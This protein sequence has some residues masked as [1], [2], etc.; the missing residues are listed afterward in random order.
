MKKIT[1][2]L[3]LMA[4][5]YFSYSQ[6]L[7]YEDLALLFSSDNNL[8]SARFN[9][10]SG[11]FGALGGDISSFKI[12]PAGA[13]V[14]SHS[15]LSVTGTNRTTNNQ[16]IYYGNAITTQ[17][18]YFNLSQAGGVFVY[19]NYVNKNW[20][21]FSLGFNFRVKNDFRD[22]FVAEGNSGFSSFN[23]FPLDTNTPPIQYNFGDSQKFV[24]TYRGE[25]SEYNFVVSALYKKDLY[26]G[27]SVNTFDLKFSQNSTLSEKNN[28]GNGNV[29][30]AFYNQQNFTLGTGFSLNAGLIYKATKSLR[31]GLSY[32]TP[33]WFTEINEETNIVNNDGFYGDTTIFT[34]NHSDT[35]DNTAGGY[36]PRQNFTYRLKTPGV[37]TASIAYIFGN[38]G[39]IS[40]DYSYKTYNN[41]K[42]SND[43]FS[44][45]NQYFLNDLRNTYSL[46]IGTEWRFKALSLRGGYLYEQSPDKFAIE[47]DNSKGYS[48]GAGYTFGNMKLDF[49]YQNKSKTQLYDF[50]QDY[51]Q[52]NPSELTIDNKIISAT[53]IFNL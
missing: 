37:S 48:F 24:N 17:D 25:L 9:A 41:I 16:S 12:N 49:S 5:S 36:F 40:A 32:Q 23:E 19:R 27:V 22:Y 43:D 29:L 30:N 8:G 38:F 6:S 18:E 50:Y 31:I 35:Y 52:V 51:N 1:F 20:S 15:M 44:S 28:D 42:L 7:G 46:R 33:T 13:A 2:S 14:F 3:F 53:L 47:S 45:E 21:K 4:C 39:L 34:S 11:A 26:V 10:M